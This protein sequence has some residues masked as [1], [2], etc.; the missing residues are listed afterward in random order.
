MYVILGATGH[1]GSVVAH[2]LL[3]QG[4]KVRVVGR[5]SKKLAPF[6]S[7]GAEA[8]AGDVLDTDAMNKAFA[9][10]EGVYA[11]IP[12]VMTSPDFRAYQEQVTDSVARA[13]ETAGVKHAVT[14]SS[15]GADKPDK[16]GPVI[17]LHNMESKFARI[18]GLNALHLRAG[19]FMENM[20]AQIGVIQGFGMMAGPVRADLPLAMIDTKDIG[21]VAAEA[22]VRLDFQGQQTRELL[23][24]RELTYNEMAGIIGT[25][26]GKPALVYIQLPDEQVVQAMTGMGISKN[27]ATLICEMAAA[28]NNGYMK[29][30]EARSAANTTPTTFETF[31]KEVFLP[32]FKG[33][34]ASA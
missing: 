33:Q 16:T 6:A 27:M 29:P 8:F 12:P 23:G 10:A 32:A 5:D 7:R 18:N 28:L 13:L 22:L 14:L 26:I 15:V 3:E 24:P 9:G 21:E 20:L 17:G 25:A 11:L 2:K 30:L 34:A 1:T 4:K 31:V 19:Y